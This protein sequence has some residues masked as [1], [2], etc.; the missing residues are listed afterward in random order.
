MENFEDFYEVLQI[1]PN[2]EAETIHRVYKLLAAR[3]HP[4]NPETGDLD[5]FLALNRAYEVLSDATSRA[6]YDVDYATQRSQPLKEFDSREFSIGVDGESNRRLGILFLLYRQR[7]S[8]P[9]NSGMS[10]LDLEA[11]MATPREHLVFT[12][13][14]LREK[15]LVRLDDRSSLLI[16]AEGVDYVENNLP[17]HGT[18]YK[19]LNKGKDPQSA[20]AQD[21]AEDALSR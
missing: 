21:F 14:Y 20:R 9:E 15:N 1:S 10:L 6:T 5:A 4:D 3:L 19:L 16:S 17:A 11:L 18:L 8:D 7:R 2:A 12:T 13:W